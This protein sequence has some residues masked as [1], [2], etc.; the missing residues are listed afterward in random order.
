MNKFDDYDTNKY[1]KEYLKQYKKEKLTY[2]MRNE[3]IKRIDTYL[4]FDI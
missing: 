1:V 3:K 2:Y 4:R